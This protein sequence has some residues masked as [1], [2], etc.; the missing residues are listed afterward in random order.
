MH[1]YFQKAHLQEVAD[2]LFPRL[3]VFL[4]GNRGFIKENNATNLI[5][6]EALLL[7]TVAQAFK[8]NAYKGRKGGLLWTPKVQNII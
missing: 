2:K 6:F 1:F 8:A 3:Q 7:L 4:K 5:V